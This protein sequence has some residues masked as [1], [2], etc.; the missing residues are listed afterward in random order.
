MRSLYYTTTLLLALLTASCATTEED[1]TA[2]W[3]PQRLYVEGK[4]ALADGNHQTAI[5]YFDKLEARFP[6]GRYAEQAMLEKAYTY[7]KDDEPEAALAAIERFIRLHPTHPHVDYAYYLKGLVNFKDRSSGL[8][9]VMGLQSD[10]ADRDP[11]AAR[12]AHDIFQDLV[13]RFPNSPYAKDSAKRAAYLLD[14]LARNEIKVARFYLERDACVAAVNRAKIV[15]EKYN[16]TPSVEHALGIQVLAYQRLGA[17]RLAED[18]ERILRKNFPQSEYLKNLPQP[19][20][21]PANHS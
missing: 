11:K 4:T 7:Y 14:A 3:S 8:A 9:G 2:N 1:P 12:E 19:E 13:K 5:D 6:Y 15:L 21:A 10:P 17:K 18:S 16:R 20:P